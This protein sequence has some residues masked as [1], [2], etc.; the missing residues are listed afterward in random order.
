MNVFCHLIKILDNYIADKSFKINYQSAINSLMYVMLNI[1]F[2]IIYFIFVINRYAIISIQKHWQTIKR[3][4]HYLQ[5]IY[6]MKLMFQKSLKR[7]KEYTNFDWI[8]DQNIK[9]LI[10]SYAFNINNKIINWS[11]KR[12]L[13]VILFICEVEYIDQ[14]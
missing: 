11:S 4:F 6:Q 12:Q 8:D 3:I 14:T 13:I 2:D 1:K 5:K 10:S 9:R 7:L